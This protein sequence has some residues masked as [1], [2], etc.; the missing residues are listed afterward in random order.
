MPRLYLDAATSAST[1][2]PTPNKPSSR[3]LSAGAIA[4]VTGG[5]IIVIIIILAAGYWYLFHV[6]FP[7]RRASHTQP[8]IEMLGQGFHQ[9]LSIDSQIT[10]PVAASPAPSYHSGIRLGSR[11]QSVLSGS[12]T[13]LGPPRVQ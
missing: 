11:R 9:N 2:T 6:A 12:S 8:G 3:K 1:G 5:V 10:N 13:G 7:R 4:G